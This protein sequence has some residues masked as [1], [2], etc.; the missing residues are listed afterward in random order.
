MMKKIIFFMLAFTPMVVKAAPIIVDSGTFYGVP[1]GGLNVSYMYI[2]YDTGTQDG[3]FYALPGINNAFSIE[4]DNGSNITVNNA[5]N[6][7]TGY[8]LTMGAGQGSELINVTLGAVNYDSGQS[9]ASGGALN[10]TNVDKFT[11]SG[12]VYAFSGFSVNANTMTSGAIDISGGNTVLNISGSLSLAQIINSGTGNVNI[13]ANDIELNGTVQ[14][15]NIGSTFTML[16][17]G[18]ITSNSGG[19]EN[20]GT[21][22]INTSEEFGNVSVATGT[23]ANSGNM[24]IY[25]NDFTI[26]GGDSANPS[27]VNSGNLKMNITGTTNLAYG[28][29]FSGMSSNNTFELITG[30]LVLGDGNSDD[31]WAQ[32]GANNLNSFVLEITNNDLNLGAGI[33]NGYN[34]NTMASMKLA[35][36]SVTVNGNITNK[37]KDLIIEGETITVNGTVNGGVSFMNV[38]Q[39]DI[40][41]IK[42]QS[43]NDI[44]GNYV[45]D[46]NSSLNA[47]ISSG[48]SYW[49][50]V[51]NMTNNSGGSTQA[52]ISVGG[53]FVSNVTEFGTSSNNTP[54]QDG[55]IGIVLNSSVDQG[56]AILLVKAENGIQE[57][58]NKIRNLNV[59]FCNEDGTSC[60]NYLEAFNGYNATSEEL[61]VYLSLRDTNGDGLAD[62]I[63]VVFDPQFGGP[64]NV[65]D[66]QPVVGKNPYHTNSE[67]ESAGALDDVVASQIANKTFSEKSPIEVIPVIFEG[68]NLAEMA[69]ELYNRM[70]DY[71]MD[72]DSTGLTSFSHLFQPYELEQ[73][74]GNIA[75]NE[76]ANF[77]SFEDRLFDEFIWNRNR[78]LKKA[79]VD[80]DF[81]MLN[82]KFADGNKSDGNRFNL[83]AGVDWQNSETVMLGL[84]GHVSNTTN[85]YLETLDLGYVPGESILGQ[86][87][88]NVENM[89]IG[90]GGYFI[91]ILG[92][93]T[94]IYGNAF[95]DMHIFDIS[96][97]QNYVAQ[98]SGSGNSFSVISEWGL[99]HDLLNQYVVGNMYV[100]AGYNFG[101]SLSEEADG[102]DYMDMKSDGYFILTPGY[103]LVAQKR[104]YP[105]TWFQIRPYASVGIEY[106]VFGV[107]DSMK[108]K[109][110][111][112][113][114][115]TDYSIDIDPLWA[116]VG[117]GV[118][119]L[120]ANGIQLGLDYRYQYNP[121]IQLNNI[122][123]SGSY[124]F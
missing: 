32:I 121:A 71:Y 20:V 103:S 91:K 15:N 83:S 17:G 30:A 44:E 40:N 63:Y 35:G 118:E 4:S 97:T 6:I 3:N 49:T 107:P 12:P 60:I 23:M 101:F 61:P 74:A 10:I 59:N 68:T 124:R 46:D 85:D 50:T 14:N 1:A 119:F 115:Y 8:T 37:G 77:R 105:S 81:G 73:I 2:G 41:T 117:G 56:S 9:T 90:L 89:N 7:A 5:L 70:D 36:Q 57:L 123:V 82:Q 100:R 11:I 21:M 22:I 95:V 19:I 108:Y 69:Q 53:T 52:L 29:D 98:I 66:I 114:S 72:L 75:L 122:K 92:E 28:F 78:S 65:F 113:E 25:A 16:A 13:A 43:G 38:G 120:S 106:D 116:N 58:G 102:Q 109:F 24:T 62:S 79:W 88:T 47:I 51:D 112:A 34:G 64:V 93:K 87:E 55:Q 27:L 18:G 45:F 86:I 54:L 42:D 104:I 94:R 111:L 39:M 99:M 31:L 26:S 76:H 96:R 48:K 80:V 67:Y 33:Y 110:A 84:T